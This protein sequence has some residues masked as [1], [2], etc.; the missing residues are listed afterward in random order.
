[1]IKLANRVILIK[2][3][4]LGDEFQ[5]KFSSAVSHLL[6]KRLQVSL[7]KMI[8]ESESELPQFKLLIF[9]Y[10]SMQRW[11]FANFLGTH[12]PLK[13]LPTMF[14]SFESLGRR[15]AI[16][17]VWTS[18]RLSAKV[19]WRLSEHRLS[20]CIWKASLLSLS[21]TAKPLNLLPRTSLHPPAF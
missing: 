11:K 10:F 14:G 12:K 5:N 3:V 13:L 18:K 6:G 9:F 8:R 19:V 7:D 2:L 17:N 21:N 4:E 1:M 20:L 15:L 16:W